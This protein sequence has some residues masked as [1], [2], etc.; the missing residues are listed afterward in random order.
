MTVKE[1]WGRIQGMDA[2]LTSQAGN[3]WTFD[4][5]PWAT[6]PLIVEFWAEDE[7]GNISYKTGVFDLNEGPKK[8][9]RWR[10]T[11]C[12]CTMLATEK[13]DIQMDAM[14]PRVEMVDHICMRML[15]A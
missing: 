11:G 2:V 9:I 7:A 3:V 14:R 8:C 5:P 6:G 12:T 13:P 4:V 1:V 10:D 15:E